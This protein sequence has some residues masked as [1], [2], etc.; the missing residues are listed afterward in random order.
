MLSEDIDSVQQEFEFIPLKRDTALPFSGPRE[1]CFFKPLG[2]ETESRSVPIEHF[3][4]FSSFAKENE[5]ISCKHTVGFMLIGKPSKPVD[6]FSHVGH[7]DHQMNGSIFLEIHP[8]LPFGS[9]DMRFFK[10]WL[11]G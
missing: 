7:P 2:P 4:D 10:N 6:L 1:G 5:I 11:T 8:L 3:H 9:Q